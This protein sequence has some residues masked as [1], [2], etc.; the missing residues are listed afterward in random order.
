MEEGST[1]GMMT[2]NT[3][4][5]GT[6]TRSMDLELISGPMEGAIVALG[7]KITC[8]AEESTNGKMEGSMK[9]NM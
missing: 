4:E 6:R 9:E 1:N 2:Q 5:C 7:K 3:T 8:M